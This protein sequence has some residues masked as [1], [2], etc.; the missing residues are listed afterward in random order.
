MKVLVK[1]LVT[2]ATGH[3]GRHL[4]PRLMEKGYSVR[5]AAIDAEEAREAFNDE[6]VEIMELDLAAAEAPAFDTLVAG[7]DAVVHMAAIIDPNAPREK[8]FRV[9]AGA[10]RKL[11]QACARKKDF[12]RFVYIS[13]SSVFHNPRKLPVEEGDEP[14]PENVYGES[15]LAAEKAVR[16]S[17][18]QFVILRPVVI[19]GLGFESL[20]APIVHAFQK[21]SIAIIGSGETHFPAVHVDDLV[22]AIVLSLEKKEALGQVFNVSGGALTQRQWFAAVADELGLSPPAKSIPVWLA[23]AVAFFYEIKTKF[24]GG[25]IAISRDSVRRL[26]TDRVFSTRKAEKL[27]GWKACVNPRDGL[28]ELIASILSRK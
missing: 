18:V 17:G 14:S 19:Y 27:L 3:V 12:K 22:S 5:V 2:G 23:N 24:F 28:S 9:N 8:L 25:S 4:I 15:K 21:G 11:A 26:T 7:V 16:E 20:F 13:S 10:T 1:V 6:P